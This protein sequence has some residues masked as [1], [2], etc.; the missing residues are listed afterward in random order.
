MALALVLVPNQSWSAPDRDGDGYDR[1]VDCDDSSN[2]INPGATELCD[3]LDNN[4]DAQIDEDCPVLGD[5]D[6]DGILDTVAHFLTKDLHLSV[7]DT[8]AVLSGKLF[9]QEG[10]TSFEGTD[11]I[12]IIR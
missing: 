8:K 4:C 10:G 6:G 2:S 1:G 12:M 5:T 11:S 9:D 3:G 7:G